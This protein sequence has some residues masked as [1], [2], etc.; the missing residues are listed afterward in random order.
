VSHAPVE[1]SASIS[2][3]LSDDEERS[4]ARSGPADADFIS[5][6]LVFA[7][8]RLLPR[9]VATECA[10]RSGALDLL[11]LDALITYAMEA[12]AQSPAQCESTANSL[13]AAIAEASA[14]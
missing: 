2:K 8:R 6:H 9:V 13:L 3:A 14:A 11:T 4:A 5:S 12:A 1:L 7:A 10:E